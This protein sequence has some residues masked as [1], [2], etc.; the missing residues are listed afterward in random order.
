MMNMKKLL[1]LLLAIVMVVGMFPMGVLA[2]ETE[3]KLHTDTCSDQ[4]ETADCGCPCHVYRHLE[5]CGEECTGMVTVEDAEAECECDCHFVH[6]ETCGEACEGKTES[7]EDCVCLCH[8]EHAPAC[9]ENCQGKTKFDEDCTCTC[10]EPATNQGG[11]L[12]KIV[13]GMKN[14]LG[15]GKPEGNTEETTEA[16]TEATTED[17]CA[18]C[19][20]TE[21]TTNLC[22]LFCG[23]CQKVPCECATCEKCGVKNGHTSTCIEQLCAICGK[24]SC[25]CPCETCGK[26][27]CECPCE[28]CEKFPCE[29]VPETTDVAEENICDCGEEAPEKL[30]EHA[31][32]CP[33]KM[34]VMS[35]FENKTA[36][37]L[38]AEWENYEEADQKDIL[39]LL[40]VYNT[41]V[42][43]SLNVLLTYGEYPT[44]VKMED[45]AVISVTD[46]PEGAWLVV[47]IPEEEK[48]DTIGMLTGNLFDMDTS[49]AHGGV[50][51]RTYDIKIMLGDEEWQPENGESIN[52]TFD[53]PGLRADYRTYL[54]GLHILDTVDAIQEAVSSGNA[55]TMTDVGLADSFPE[56][57]SAAA[58]AGFPENTIVYTILLPE[59]GD[60]EANN[61][62]VVLDASSF[63]TYTITAFNVNNAESSGSVPDSGLKMNKTA[64]VNV[65]TG[66][67]F[68]ELSSYVKGQVSNTPIDVVLVIDQ[69]GSMWTAVDPSKT[70]TNLNELDKEKGAR[71]GYYV[72]FDL[73]TLSNT[74]DETG[75]KSE[76]GEARLLRFKDGN[77]QACDPLEATIYDY[78]KDD[79]C[80][81]VGFIDKC[82]FDIEAEWKNINSNANYI[83]AASISGALYEALNIFVDEMKSAVNC[84]VAITTF[85]GKITGNGTTDAAVKQDVW[86]KNLST[87]GSTLE[88]GEDYVGS[89]IFIDGELTWDSTAPGLTDQ[90]YANAF[91]D[92]S[93]AAGQNI[94]YNTIN[95]INTDY[96]NTPTALGLLYARRLFI[97]S[98]RANAEKVVIVFTDGI[99]SPAYLGTRKISENN[100]KH[101]S[102]D[103]KNGN[104]YSGSA[105]DCDYCDLV[106]TWD[107]SETGYAVRSTYVDQATELKKG[108]TVYSIGPKAGRAGT[109]VLKKIAT[110]EDHYWNAS[111]DDI[112]EKFREIAGFIV[113]ASQVVDENSRVTDII[114]SSFKLPEGTDAANEDKIEVYTAAYQGTDASGEDTFSADLVK[115]NEAEVEV[116][117]KTIEVWGFDYVEQAV[118]VEG[119]QAKGSKLVVKI[120]I[121]PEPDFLGGENVPTNELE[122]GIYNDSVCVAPFI[123][124]EV[125]VNLSRI[126]PKFDYDHIF[127]SQSAHIPKL[128]NVGKFSQNQ[129]N[130][131]V[132]GDNNK[133]VNILY[134]V[135]ELNSNG[136]G[137]GKYLTCMIPAGKSN[138]S[139]FIWEEQDL[140]QNP[141]LENDT[142]YLITCTVSSAKSNPTLDPIERADTADVYVYKPEVTF[143]DSEMNLGET[144]NYEDTENEI[145]PHNLVSVV[146]K[147]GGE[148]YTEGE[149]TT[150]N[151]AVQ[152]E[153]PALVFTYNP[154]AGKFKTET[155]VTVEKVMSNEDES[156]FVYADMDILS[157]TTFYRESCSFANCDMKDHA[158]IKVTGQNP[159]HFKVHLK[160]F[161]LLITKDGT[162]TIDS[163]DKESQ[164]YIFSVTRKNPTTQAVEFSIDVTIV[165]DDEVLIKSLPAGV[166]EVTELVDWSWRY[167]PKTGVITVSSA[168]V[169][170]YG[171]VTAA[172]ENQRTDIY[173]L[174]GDSYCKNW[175]NGSD[176]QKTLAPTS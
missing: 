18:L 138:A 33:R 116:S 107:G 19:E 175:W 130:F 93:T 35:F 21:H 132:D 6:E 124:P 73:D 84:R 75:K 1:A 16:T 43:A 101:T 36:D 140:T 90:Q 112:A 148:V 115:F 155:S 14:L 37:E 121:K 143:R 87:N 58:A 160:N 142:Q 128:M 102:D 94:L 111:G 22:T 173:W 11:I 27:P 66:E 86:R 105:L 133:Y 145:V 161:D 162:E 4:C 135:E 52:V 2:Q 12:N 104:K 47:T 38:Y 17:Q 172:F 159:T 120:P 34:Y 8:A 99:P 96:G 41:S 72:A 59:T 69:S 63:S 174:S 46:I 151:H 91:E 78:D 9:V 136:T 154:V 48:A 68:I 24:L 131:T 13:D 65:T 61:G 29:C 114:S 153:P 158:T 23:F 32:S 117:G 167:R 98:Q 122:S 152:G 129:G 3:A 157:G 57:T 15:A 92:P 134:K 53:I 64:T 56:E 163:N 28:T 76:K 146:W 81:F 62:N 118:R 149:H 127:L 25:E 168:N 80:E 74:T 141:V 164:T 67:G 123:S 137:T 40:E 10:H 170:E 171:K 49:V 79:N 156:N 55:M 5:N 31:D 95:K 89:G 85:A 70:T 139:D 51:T 125:N 176:I 71:R 144:A 54:Q 100:C 147:H 88:P 30:A 166:Y 42:S 50:F 45:G 126:V 150:D 165:G 103:Y 82:A 106:T 110:S 44:S 26:F 119:S 60:M 169:D 20:S 108:A 77:W 83:Y 109:D 97:K 7:G 113:S 39:A